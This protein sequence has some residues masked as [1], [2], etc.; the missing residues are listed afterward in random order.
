MD[1]MSLTKLLESGPAADFRMR[2]W[3][4]VLRPVL[5]D[6]AFYEFQILRSHA[7]SEF[8]GQEKWRFQ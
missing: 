3:T 4:H 6:I 1:T 7:E 2:P 5:R 8:C